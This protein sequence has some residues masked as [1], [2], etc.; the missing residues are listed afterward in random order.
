MRC[1][2]EVWIRKRP[3][4]GNIG[5][6]ETGPER[7]SSVVSGL[8]GEITAAQ[9]RVRALEAMLG[10]TPGVP[11]TVDEAAVHQYLAAQR[12]R[13]VELRWRRRGLVGD[14]PGEA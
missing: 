4:V 3:P 5:P 7:A 9:R 1:W 2:T 8:D 11:Q 12:S 13:C 14:G 10:A 6:G